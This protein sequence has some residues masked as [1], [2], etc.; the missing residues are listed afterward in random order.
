LIDK[1]VYK[2]IEKKAELQQKRIDLRLRIR[3]NM[4]EIRTFST[5]GSL[6]EF[7]NVLG[8]DKQVG[9][10]P[11]MGALHQGHISLVEQAEKDNDIV[12]VS[13]FVNPKQFNNSTDL[14]RYPR[15][16]EA[17]LKMLSGHNAIVYNPGS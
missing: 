7:I 2:N 6:T 11:T 12:V 9:V 15:T 16:L 14:E 8:P 4:R 10:V 13:I 1:N 3:D 5:R 17:D